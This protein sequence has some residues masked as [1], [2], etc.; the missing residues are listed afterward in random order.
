MA[1]S[2]KLRNR[3]LRLLQ[4][5]RQFLERG[6]KRFS[7]LGIRI[8]LQPI[9]EY[10]CCLLKP[11]YF[12]RFNDTLIFPVQKNVISKAIP[13]SDEPFNKSLICIISLN[14]KR[15]FFFLS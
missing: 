15:F 10:S 11:S 13:V 3:I 12:K 2:T 14:L 4:L 5:N 9:Y 6:L 1:D 7:A 8:F